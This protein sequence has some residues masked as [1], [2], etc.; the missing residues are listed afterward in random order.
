MRQPGYMQQ[1]A[2]LGSLSLRCDL[3]D[4]EAVPMRPGDALVVFDIDGLPAT[5]TLPERDI[6]LVAL[7]HRANRILAEGREGTGVRA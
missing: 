5:L 3:P 7:P 2:P 6:D 4:P 1:V